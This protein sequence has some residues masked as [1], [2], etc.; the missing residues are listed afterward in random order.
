MSGHQ[1]DEFTTW[2][3]VPQ[4]LRSLEIEQ[5]WLVR[6]M[7]KIC[8]LSSFFALV[9]SL[10]IFF[11]FWGGENYIRKKFLASNFIIFF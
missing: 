7:E 9:F 11:F 5:K 3:R 6:V 4:K 8:G 10:L 1:I 2:L